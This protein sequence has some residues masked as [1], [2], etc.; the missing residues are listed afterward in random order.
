MA[1]KAP[2]LLATATARTTHEQ[3]GRAQGE[4]IEQDCGMDPCFYALDVVVVSYWSAKPL[5]QLLAGLPVPSLVT[6]VDNADAEDL[7]AARLCAPVTYRRMG[8]NHG[9]GCAANVG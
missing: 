5:A 6:V 4:R 3:F 7:D 2:H 8:R 1:R 9:F